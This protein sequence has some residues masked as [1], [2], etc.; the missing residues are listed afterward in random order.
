MTTGTATATERL[1]R[2]LALVPYVVNRNVV[3]MQD[4]ATAFGITERELVE[5]RLMPAAAS[6]SAGS[7]RSE[8]RSED[9]LTMLPTVTWPPCGAA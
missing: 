1:Q 9:V 2:L 5:T 8:R 3:G 7:I 4:T 6:M